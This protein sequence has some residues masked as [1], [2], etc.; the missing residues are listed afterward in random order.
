MI[1]VTLISAGGLLF[2]MLLIGVYF[3]K[4]KQTHVDNLFF[5]MALI[6]LALVIISE[7]T[8]VC[9]I[10]YL[11]NK[12]IGNFLSRVNGVVTISWITVLYCYISSLGEVFDK[13]GFNLYIKEG[14]KLKIVL[15]SYVIS[16]AMFFFLK[17]DNVILEKSAYMSGSALYYLYVVGF[18]CVLVSSLAVVRNINQLSMKQRI[19]IAVGLITVI[20][21]MAAQIIFPRVLIITSGFV[22]AMYIAYFVFENPD[23]YLIKE[24]EIAKN[25]ADDSNR[26]KSDF[27]SNMSHEI[28]TPMNAIIGFSEGILNDDNMSVEMSKKDISHI[29]LASSNLLEIINN[30]LD[31]SKIETGEEK[32]EEKPYELGNIILE[33][34][35]IIE[36]R[37]NKEKVKFVTNVDPNIPSEY[38]GDKTKLFQILLNIL[39][40]SAKYTEIGKIEISI[41]GEKQGNNMILHFKISDTGF[42][43]KKEDYDKLF[44]KFARLDSAT[45]NE[46]EGTGLGLVITKKLVNLLNGK[47]WFESEYGAGTVFYVDIIQKIHNHDK[48]GEISLVKETNKVENYLDCSK[49]KILI[50]DD[51]KLNLKVAQKVLSPYK[52]NITCLNGGKEC[53]DDIKSG[54]EYDLIFMDHMMPDI[55][56]IETLKILKKLDGYHICPVV[57]LTANAINGMREMYLEAG[58]DD[59]LSKPINTSELDKIINKYFNR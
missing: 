16:I 44:E 41:T 39:S 50:V 29:Y 57:A 49:Y 26:A 45:K 23:L 47:I 28:R 11:P 55:D 24:L 42:G 13:N 19:P 7:I 1:E 51:N 36:A 56:G 30:I 34:R 2:L 31:I 20:I 46:I 25:R 22:L 10:Y 9:F 37:I 17:Y 48:I 59:Y 15:I 5:K 14:N 53:I 40:N 18:I 38:I 58:F 52:F 54:N 3:Y 6:T 4:A 8:A 43:I 21:F 33:L 12:E 35:S 32:V 27:L